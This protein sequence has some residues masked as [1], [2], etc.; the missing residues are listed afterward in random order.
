[1][2]VCVLQR[3]RAAYQGLSQLIE[4]RVAR[5]LDA[6]A[7]LTANDAA[8]CRCDRP[9]QTP[10]QPRRWS[11][12]RFRPTQGLIGEQVVIPMR[13]VVHDESCR[14]IDRWV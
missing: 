14:G 5:G 7:I 9:C 12:R 8:C 11:G 3:R 4:G 10:R 1:M 13:A 6:E 2:A